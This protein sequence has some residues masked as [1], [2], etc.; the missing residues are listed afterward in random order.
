[1][2]KIGFCAVFLHELESHFCSSPLVFSSFFHFSHISNI[3]CRVLL[4][5]HKC[6]KYFVFLNAVGLLLLRFSWIIRY[7]F[8]V[9][10]I[11]SICSLFVIWL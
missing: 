10:L 6:V 3:R 11:D 4:Y 5:F 9:T 1:M 7:D 2:L 8:Y